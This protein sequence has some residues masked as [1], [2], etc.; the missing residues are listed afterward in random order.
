MD[1]IN[2]KICNILF[3]DNI[4][5]HRHLKSHKITQVEYYQSYFPRYDRYD[6]S[7][8]KFKSKEYYFNNDF[9]SKSN[10]K[11]WLSMVAPTEA[12]LYVKTYFLKRKNLGKWNWAPTQVELK[13]LNSIPGRNWITEQFGD[14]NTFC[15]TL[16]LKPRFTKHELDLSLFK[17]ISNKVIFTDK[18]E[19][20]PLSFDNQTRYK[21]MSFGD[22][23]TANSNVYIERKAL[24]DAW[25]SLSSGLERF[26][27][28]IIRAKNAGAYLIVLVESP[29]NELAQFPYQRQVRGKIKMSVECIYHTIR[30][31]LQKYL[32]I[33]FLFCNNR[34]EASRLVEKI[35]SAGEQIQNVDLQ[36][37]LDKEKL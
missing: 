31:L 11:R 9:N 28:E 19:Q 14:Y 32:N 24:G 15:E 27:R 26:E 1:K 21:S 17:D 36:F 34:D 30:M 3:N 37:L 7:I 12:Q 10:F 23:R 25:G 16:G 29:F 20:N 35:F 4:T 18:R 8:I 6:N 33:Q 13:S 22:Y 2:C 5:F